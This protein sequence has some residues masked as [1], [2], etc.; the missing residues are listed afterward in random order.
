ME[1][2]CLIEERQGLHISVTSSENLTETDISDRAAE[3]SNR[4]PQQG[5]ESEQEWNAGLNIRGH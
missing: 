5:K 3:E 4:K 2:R 1:Y